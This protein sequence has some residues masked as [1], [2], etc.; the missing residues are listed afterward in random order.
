MCFIQRHNAHCCFPSSA[1][2]SAIYL[3]PGWPIQWKLRDLLGQLK[4]RVGYNVLQKRQKGFQIHPFSSNELNQDHSLESR[5]FVWLV[6]W[7]AKL[8]LTMTSGMALFG[9][10]HQI[11]IS[12]SL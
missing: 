11:C 7:L 10:A 6:K 9:G 8:C 2:R 12:F 1:I 3:T 4:L 5:W